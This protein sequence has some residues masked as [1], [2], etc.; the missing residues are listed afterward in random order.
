MRRYC[1]APENSW[2]EGLIRD[3]SAKSTYRTETCYSVT[4]CSSPSL[5]TVR[6]LMVTCM[7]ALLQCVLVQCVC[8]LTL[9]PSVLLLAGWSG[10]TLTISSILPLSLSLSFSLLIHFVWPSIPTPSSPPPPPPPR[11]RMDGLKQSTSLSLS[12]F[13]VFFLFLWGV[14][15]SLVLTDRSNRGSLSPVLTLISIHW[16]ASGISAAVIPLMAAL[17]SLT[18]SPGQP[19]TFSCPSRSLLPFCAVTLYADCTNLQK[20]LVLHDFCN[21]N[22][23]Y[24]TRFSII[25]HFCGSFSE[26]CISLLWASAV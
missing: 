1:K 3:Q 18:P 2:I 20:P 12:F 6:V 13:C 23:D 11:I 8:I 7:W 21:Q 25:L 15:L 10:A 16:Y 9:A 24:Y 17:E 14:F 19:R 5:I 22:D 4:C 26:V